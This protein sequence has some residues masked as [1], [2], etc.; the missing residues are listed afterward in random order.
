MFY[1]RG[2]SFGRGKHHSKDLPALEM[3]G[4]NNGNEDDKSSE[5]EGQ[6]PPGGSGQ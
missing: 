3:E 6:R 5:E 1:K 4:D 2:K